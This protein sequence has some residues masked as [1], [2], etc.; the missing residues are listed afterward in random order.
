MKIC[1]VF[2]LIM[3]SVAFA[4]TTQVAELTFDTRWSQPAAATNSLPAWVSS[5][6]Q[7]S[8]E[9][10]DSPKCWHVGEG[11]PVGQGRLTIS[12]DRTL[13]A[14]DLALQLLFRENESADLVVQLFDEKDRVI[15]LDLFANVIAVG[16]DAR[17]DTF[18]VPFRKYPTATK[19]VVRRIS[20]DVAVYGMVLYPVVGQAEG[21]DVT[22]RELA[23]LLGDPL[24]PGNPL[25]TH[26]DQL[27]RDRDL[28]LQWRRAEIQTAM[29]ARSAPV[30]LSDNGWIALPFPKNSDWPGLKGLT[31]TLGANDFILRGQPIRS[32][33]SFTVPL[34]ISCDIVL[35]E[36]RGNDGSIGFA[37]Q[38]EGVPLDEE[39]A[40]IVGVR[41]IYR[42]P[43][44]YSG[45]DE[46]VAER[47]ISMQEGKTI[48]GGE[49]F[50]VAAGQTYHVTLDVLADKMRLT[51]GDRTYSMPGVVVP[52]P[53]FQITVHGW[54]PENRWHV[55]NLTVH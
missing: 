46:L 40:Q 14:E 15:V 9:F 47:R 22:L 36:R 53:K 19:I 4:G 27:A 13:M 50:P 26:I 52:Y 1:L 45:K 3:A 51:I 2:F 28:K 30:A 48:W 35:E 11:Q 54:K 12:V 43:G 44:A 25:T 18:I 7:Q 39:S 23:R 10:I 21:D 42:N 24:S 6:S 32:R 37:F 17:T 29:P 5:V 49:P 38:P 8:G 41:M 16:K 33:C 31:A 55:R 34:T 20:G